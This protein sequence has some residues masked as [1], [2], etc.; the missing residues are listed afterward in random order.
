[1]KRP[2]TNFA[3]NKL[4]AALSSTSSI[5]RLLP[6]LSPVRLR[7]DA[8]LHEHGQPASDI[9]FPTSSMIALSCMAT[10]G[11]VSELTAVGREGMAGISAIM[12]VAASGNWATVV[13]A[14][15]AWRLPAKVLQREFA[16][17][18]ACR[19]LLL[20]Y[21]HTLML[22]ISHHS[23]CDTRH[24]L[25]QRLCRLLLEMRDRGASDEFPATQESMAHRLGVR[26]ESVSAAARTLQSIGVIRYWRGR[27]QVVD[28]ETL[29][30]LSCDCY[31]PVRAEYE[32][33]YASCVVHPAADWSRTVSVRQH[34]NG[35]HNQWVTHY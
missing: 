34:S 15:E 14:G 11:S 13:R 20:R 7:R 18:E 3:S 8:V 21:L 4:L 19:G 29:A 25:Q 35:S 9:Y 33:L 16:T 31:E 30:A 24:C 5:G 17:D 12:G 32:H 10:D 26:R 2:S 22:D 6:H 27:I 23:L 28:S 1:M